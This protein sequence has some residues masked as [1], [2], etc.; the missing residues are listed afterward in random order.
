MVYANCSQD[1]VRYFAYQ[2]LWLV[3]IPII[4]LLLEKNILNFIPESYKIKTKTFIKIMAITLLL[5]FYFYA[6]YTINKEIPM[7]EAL[8]QSFGISS[9]DLTRNFTTNFSNFSK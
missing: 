7:S 5:G 8:Q 9:E 2:G 4:L 1:I 3:L 6:R